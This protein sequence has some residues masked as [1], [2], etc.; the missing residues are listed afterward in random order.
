V[1]FYYRLE[2]DRLGDGGEE[3]DEE[4]WTAFTTGGALPGKTVGQYVR[5]RVEL[6]PDGS[7]SLSPR[8]MGFT[9][10]YEKNEPPPPPSFVSASAG[11]GEVRLKWSAVADARL[12][13]YALYYGSRPGVYDVTESALGPSPLRLGKETS[14]TLGGLTNGK[15]YYFALSSYD[16]YSEW[17]PGQ[18]SKEVSSRPSRLYHRE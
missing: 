6:F 17:L 11:D 7:G 10:V 12:E 3:R 5:V 9:I 4:R 15:L 2:E 8:L 16:E 18:F 1:F 14:V 13:G